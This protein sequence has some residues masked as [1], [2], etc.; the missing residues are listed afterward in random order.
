MKKLALG[1]AAV[2]AAVMLAGSAEAAAPRPTLDQYGCRWESSTDN[3]RCYRGQFAGRSFENQRHMIQVRLR[4]EN[5]VP[6]YVDDDG[7]PR[8]LPPHNA[9][10]QS[11]PPTD[12]G[13]WEYELPL[14]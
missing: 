5:W 11:L 12:N 9:R 4:H 7:A 8:V 2:T 3:Y 10:G 6:V 1:L 14:R 13:A